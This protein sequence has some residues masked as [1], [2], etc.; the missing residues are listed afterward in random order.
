M[1]ADANAV[2]TLNVMRIYPTLI[3]SDHG[4]RTWIQVEPSNIMH[5]GNNYVNIP[6]VHCLSFLFCLCLLLK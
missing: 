5:Y 3:I 4:P 2:L 1:V 6:L